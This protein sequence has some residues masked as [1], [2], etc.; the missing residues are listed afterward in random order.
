VNSSGQTK[1]IGIGHFLGLKLREWIESE[2]E[3]LRNGVAIANLLIDSLGENDSL[4]G[5]IRDLTSHPLLLQALYSKGASQKAALGSLSKQLAQTY[6][7]AVLH[8]LIALVEAA[9]SRKVNY[10]EDTGHASNAAAEV[11]PTEAFSLPTKERLLHALAPGIALGAS[12][13]LVFS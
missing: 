12:A 8:Q 6:T 7:P 3:R 4:R 10:L 5:P 13:A 1:A 11:I 2:P 9:T